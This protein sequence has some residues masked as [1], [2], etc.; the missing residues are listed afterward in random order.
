M[1]FELLFYM[2][3]HAGEVLSAE[4]LLQEVWGYPPGTGSPDL[5]R[6]HIRNL[7]M[8]IE[9]SPSSPTYIQTISRH[10]YVIRGNEPEA[11]PEPE[12]EEKKRLI[13]SL[14]KAMA[15]SLKRPGMSRNV[16][17]LS[18]I[19]AVLLFLS[20]WIF[21]FLAQPARSE[22]L[23]ALR[24][25]MGRAKVSRTQPRLLWF[26]ETH[27][28]IVEEGRT[29]LTRGDRIA[30][31]EA[32][33]AVLTFFEGSTMDLWPGTELAIQQVQV[34]ANATPAL[35]AIEV[36]A[37]ETMN[38]VRSSP[39]LARR[40]EVETP[41]LTASAEDATFRVEVI[42]ETHTYLAV[43]QG[44]IQVEMGQQEASLQA[45]EEAEAIAGQP[46]VV[47]PHTLRINGAGTTI[48]TR[49]Q[50]IIVDGKGPPN[51]TALVYVN[52]RQADRVQ[53]DDVGNF[54]YVFTAP[55]EGVYRLSVAMDREGDHRTEPVTIVYD[56]T[57]P[58]LSLFTD[59]PTPEVSTSPILL[60]GRSEAGA[61]VTVNGREVPVDADGRF[62]IPW[63][64]G[65]GLNVA[66][67]VATDQ[68]GN[69]SDNAVFVIKR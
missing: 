44:V 56:R 8:K 65:P 31:D 39:S 47:G 61:R 26:R 32:S 51:S 35:I 14:Y 64:L 53:T 48:I 38:R 54:G 43:Y 2:M 45:G 29:S 66:R 17:L 7:R 62:S 28:L 13:P 15:S 33:K 9:P 46:L 30:V 63:E 68:A 18:R 60:A 11:L 67:V 42:S 49:E 27:P 50:A 4:R 40:F 21:M 36:S 22:E 3:S 24:V 58:H 1:E 57:P 69:T 5:V 25:Q 20:F 23:S 37:G 12:E 19:A 34:G 10:G 55:E 59:P 6:V 16:L 41:L 52:G